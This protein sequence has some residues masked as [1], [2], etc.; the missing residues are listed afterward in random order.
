MA[1]LKN[2]IVTVNGPPHN[3]QIHH[4]YD[5]EKII[6][7]QVETAH[8]PIEPTEITEGVIIGLDKVRIRFPIVVAPYRLSIFYSCVLLSNEKVVRIH[9]SKNKDVPDAIWVILSCDVPKVQTVIR[10]G[11]I[12]VGKGFD[13]IFIC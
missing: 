2:T 8:Y 6:H 3:F 13:N 5:H 4:E 7:N 11:M 1:I 9:T 12:K 10:E